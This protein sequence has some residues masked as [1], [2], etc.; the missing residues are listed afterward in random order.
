VAGANLSSPAFR[1]FSVLLPTYFP[2]SAPCKNFK[3]PTKGVD[4]E[5][6]NYSISPNVGD[7]NILHAV[8]PIVKAIYFQRCLAYNENN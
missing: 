6:G 2:L 3:N 5:E 8:F 4:P 1:P 7:T